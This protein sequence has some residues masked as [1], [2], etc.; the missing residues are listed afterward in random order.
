MHAPKGAPNVLLILTDDVGFGA[1]SPFGGPIPTPTF[2]RLA[3]NG[4]RYTQFHTCALCSP[5]R[6]A[7]LTGRNHHSDAT[8]CIM[9]A[10]TGFPGYNTLTPKSCGTF[11]EVLRQNGYNT[12]WYGKN[13]NIPDWHTSQAGPFDLWPTGLGFDHFYGFIGGEANQWA[14]GLY[15]DMTKVELPHDP[16]YHLMTDLANQA[17]KWTSFQKSLAPETLLIT[18][19][20]RGRQRHFPVVVSV[21]GG[22]V[23]PRRRAASAGE[24][25]SGA[26]RSRRRGRFLLQG[27][28]DRQGKPLAATP[29]RT[30]FVESIMVFHVPPPAWYPPSGYRPSSGRSGGGAGG[31]CGALLGLLLLGAAIAYFCGGGPRSSSYDPPVPG[32]LP[33]L[34]TPHL[35]LDGPS[36]PPPPSLPG[37]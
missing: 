28:C 21:S 35:S 31:G 12:A 15:E 29:P 4:L 34:D 27:R 5:T 13:H 9:E 26:V 32:P 36:L 23:N 33:S 14:P 30:N 1:T 22:R 16:K 11:A 25:I 7:P 2:D 10:G 8:G 3:R 18:R 17:I 24:K 19:R 6:A 20:P 37:N